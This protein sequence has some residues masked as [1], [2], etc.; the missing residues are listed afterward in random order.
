MLKRKVSFFFQKYCPELPVNYSDALL[1]LSANSMYE[2]ELREQIN[3]WASISE[4]NGEGLPTTAQMTIYDLLPLSIK[5]KVYQEPARTPDYYH[6]SEVQY[7]TL[8][9]CFKYV[10]LNAEHKVIGGLAG[11]ILV[12]GDNFYNSEQPYNMHIVLAI[13]AVQLAPEYQQKGYGKEIIEGLKFLLHQHL[14]QIYLNPDIYQLR[15]K[16]AIVLTLTGTPKSVSG[17]KWLTKLADSIRDKQLQLA[18][19]IGLGSFSFDLCFGHQIENSIC[20]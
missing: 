20:I 19:D 7:V 14:K 8:E 12:S 9:T 10:I 13:D 15:N 6:D 1:N 17:E 5:S 18:K 2:S 11:E 4:N 16:I 3:L